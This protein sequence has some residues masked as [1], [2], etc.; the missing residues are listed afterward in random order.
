MRPPD[1][2]LYKVLGIKPN[3]NLATI[4]RAHRA[5][6][7]RAHPDKRPAADAARAHD[8]MVRINTAWEVLR[9][10][11]KRAERRLASLR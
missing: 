3:A 7:H 2:D 9:D 11:H 5:C 6:V 4:R 1:Y 8:D 10:P